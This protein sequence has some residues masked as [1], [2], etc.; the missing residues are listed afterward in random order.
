MNVIPEAGKGEDEDGE[1]GIDKYL[2]DDSGSDESD[3][4]L[5]DVDN[6]EARQKMNLLMSQ[7][8]D[9]SD[10][11][12]LVD[13]TTEQHLRLCKGLAPPAQ[14]EID[15]RMVSFGKV[16]RHK[17]LILD[18]DET[19][20][21]AMIHDPSEEGKI[22]DCDFSFILPGGLGEQDLLVSVKERP[23]W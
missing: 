23:Y 22:E 11:L 18:M 21:H 10:L 19:L 6:E 16:T 12:S 7:E 2:V 13:E 3:D 4:V 5:E 14:A 1:G 20:I 9:D 15:K 17:T 8:T